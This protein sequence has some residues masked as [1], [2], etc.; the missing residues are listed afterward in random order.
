M[1][2]M[3]LQEIRVLVGRRVG[4]VGLQMEMG[5]GMRMQM[6]VLVLLMARMVVVMAMVMVARRVVIGLFFIRSGHL[7]M[8][9][10]FPIVAEHLVA[11]SRDSVKDAL[12]LV[13]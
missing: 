7:I 13:Q 3:W 12:C 10:C 8:L 9:L 5:L 2:R 4:M 1:R 6:A 11:E